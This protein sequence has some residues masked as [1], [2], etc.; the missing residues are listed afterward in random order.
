MRSCIDNLFDATNQAL[1]ARTV[2][3]GK[4]VSTPVRVIV[5]CRVQRPIREVIAMRFDWA[6]DSK[7]HERWCKK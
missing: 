5:E 1:D 3:E 2:A 7:I 6:L 4:C